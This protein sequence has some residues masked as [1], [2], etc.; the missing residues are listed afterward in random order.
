MKSADR[1]KMCSNCDG[2]IPFDATQCPYC[3]AAV[4]TE[5]SSGGTFKNQSIQESLTSLYSP[6]Y[7]SGS[8]FDSEEKKAAPRAEEAVLN[9]KSEEFSETQGFWPILLLTLGANL[10]TLG[11]LQFFFAENGVVKLEISGGY[12]FLFLLLSVPLF[13]FGLRQ[14]NK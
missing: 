8:P 12:W 3:F 14:A 9:A 5:S 11:V 6:P 2:R 13:Y 10:F 1:Q 4:Q 7:K